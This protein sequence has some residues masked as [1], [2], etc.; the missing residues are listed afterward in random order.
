MTA[1]WLSDPDWRRYF[2]DVLGLSCSV[3][4]FNSVPAKGVSF[5]VSLSV[6][7][8]SGRRA[9]RMD[10][11]SHLQAR[12]RRFR[13]ANIVDGARQGSEGRV[14]IA[15]GWALPLASRGCAGADPDPRPAILG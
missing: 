5:V 14:G 12:H 1:R 11:R 2:A 15:A 8:G 13:P 10:A 3:C 9:C 6:I 7:L 4:G